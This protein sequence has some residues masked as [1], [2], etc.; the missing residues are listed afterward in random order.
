MRFILFHFCSMSKV[1][2][3]RISQSL[4]TYSFGH[5]SFI[6][7]SRGY[8]KATFCVFIS[9]GPAHPPTGTSSRPDDSLLL[10]F[11]PSGYLWSDIERLPSYA[12]RHRHRETIRIW[13]RYVVNEPQEICHM[14][15]MQLIFTNMELYEDAFG[16]FQGL[17]QFD[18]NYPL[19]I[20]P[21]L[22]RK[23]L[24]LTTKLIWVEGELFWHFK[25]WGIWFSIW[26]VV[27]RI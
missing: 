13:V 9:I 1:V 3:L 17:K 18:N 10:F 15:C 8:K 20:K 5:K 21:S 6:P 22:R 24:T 12:M 11:A 27:E 4:Y 14:E 7:C 26:T 25:G 19:R 23:C 16:I 2:C